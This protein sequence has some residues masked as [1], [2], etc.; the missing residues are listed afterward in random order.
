MVA[1]VQ[2]RI[3]GGYHGVSPCPVLCPISPFSMFDQGEKI[4]EDIFDIIDREADG[5]DSLE[6]SIPGCQ[7]SWLCGGLATPLEINLL[8]PLRWLSR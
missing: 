2:I 6:V 8:G 1:V 7:W 5:S 4:H 3:K